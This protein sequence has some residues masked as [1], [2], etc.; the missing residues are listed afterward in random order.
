MRNAILYVFDCPRPTCRRALSYALKYPSYTPP[1]VSMT[2]RPESLAAECG[3]PRGFDVFWRGS[4]RPAREGRH[5]LVGQGPLL[6]RRAGPAGGTAARTAS[7]LRCTATSA[8]GSWCR[9]LIQCT[10]TWRIHTMHV[11]AGMLTR[12]A[13]WLGAR[14]SKLGYW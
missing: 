11:R 12:V 9:I 2:C 13:H 5:L 7:C 14:D 10:W 8:S 6:A 1:S 4:T 3:K